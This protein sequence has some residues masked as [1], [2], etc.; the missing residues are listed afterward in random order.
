MD[1]FEELFGNQE[2]SE[3]I[4]LNRCLYE[5]INN[6]LDTF[7]PFGSNGL[8]IFYP[9]EHDYLTPSL[10]VLKKKVSAQLKKYINL[11][12]GMGSDEQKTTFDA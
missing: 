11:R 8:P 6:I 5:A 4:I 10:S 9:C 12:L 1:N 7:R 3:Q 2:I